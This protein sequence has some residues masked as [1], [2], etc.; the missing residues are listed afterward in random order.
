MEIQKI[1][2]PEKI[3]II[4]DYREK[5]IVKN[6]KRLDTVVNEQ[7]LE[8]A[9]FICSDDVGIERK[10]Y[11]DFIS[12][13]IDGRIFEQAVLLKQN[14]PKAVLLIEGYS[15][16][17]INE[18]SLKGAVASLIVDYGISII[19]TR[20]P[21][22]TAKTIYWIS[23]KEQQEMRKGISVRIG[24]K[25]KEF[26]RIQEFIVSS[27][28]GI[29]LILARRLLQKFGSVEKVFVADEKELMK[30]KGIGKK[31]A[32]RIKDVVAKRYEVLS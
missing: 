21:A 13:I 6:L 29:S 4:A 8:V 25:P 14:F 27:L 17:E 18:N 19:S 32:K 3:T 23:K 30:V 5:E 11:D 10:T 20:N 15:N 16:R 31:E 2:K 12:S 9:D 22:D 28:P 1:L 7:S 24:K 26:N